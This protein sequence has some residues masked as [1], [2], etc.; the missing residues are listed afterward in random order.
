[1][2]DE[3][4]VA[5]QTSRVHGIG[6]KPLIVAGILLGIVAIAGVFAIALNLVSQQGARPKPGSPAPDFTLALYPGYRAGLPEQI[7]LSDLRGQVVVMNFW[8]SWCVEC[9]KEADALEAVYRKYKDRGVI[10]L[11]IDY[12]D[13]EAPAL[14]YLKQYDVTYPNGLDVQQRIARAYRITGVPETFFIDRNG[15]VREVIIAPLTEAQLIA[16][17]EA[18]LAE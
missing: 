2:V 8:A 18:L 5:R 7:R 9:Y 3:P 14:A 17:I 1:M 16:K 11:G 10:F 12:L 15:V 4:S 6:G 13:T